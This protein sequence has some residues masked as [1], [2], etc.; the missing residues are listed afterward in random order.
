MTHMAERPAPPAPPKK[1]TYEQ[2]LEW[3]DEDTRA[4]WVDG[5]IVWMS[6]VSLTHQTVALF[7]LRVFSD[8]VEAHQSGVVLYESF[9]MKTKRSGRE[10]DILF[11]SQANLSRLK[12]NYLDG[13]ADLAVEVVSPESQERD[14]V[15]KFSEYE[16]NGVGEYWLID[17]LHEQ[18]EFYRRGSDGLF[19]AV[20]LNDDGTYRSAVLPGLW[21]RVAWLWQK[22]L[23][24]MTFVRKELGLP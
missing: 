14:R 17:P 1:M 15:T 9:Q 12:E 5:E 13:P 11:V 18:A 8:F 2:F 16:Q 6:P 20:P 22:P 19:H 10:P 3:A 23:P 4:E 24:S 21:L 7:L